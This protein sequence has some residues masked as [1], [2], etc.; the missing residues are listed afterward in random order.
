[1]ST[2]FAWN[3]RGLN[4][5]RR[6]RMTREWINIHRPLLGAFLETHVQENNHSRILNAIPVGWR[7]FGNFAEHPGG[8]IVVVWDPSVSVF[9]YSASAQAVT[10]GIFVM[11]ENINFTVTFVYGSNDVE[12]R[13]SLWNELS[14]MNRTTPVAYSPWS[15]VGDFNQIIRVSNHSDYPSSVIDISGMEDMNMALQDA[16]LFE[17]QA[18]GSPFTWWNNQVDN[19]ISKKIDHALIN[20]DWA[21]NFP[22]SYAE[23]LEPDQSDHAPCA[24]KIPCLNRQ[25]RKPF[26][27]FHHVLDHP[28]YAATISEAWQPDQFSGSNQYK[29]VRSLKCLKGDLR[30]LNKTH[31]SDISKRVKEQSRVVEGLQRTLLSTPDSTTAEEEHRE[32]A[33]LNVLLTAEQKFFRQRSRVRWADVGDRNTPFFHKTVAQRVTRNHIHFLK[34][35]NDQ[36]IGTATGIKAHSAAYFERIL[37]HTDMPTSPVTVDELQGLLDF[38]CSELQQRYLSREVSAAEIRATV[39]SMPLNKSSGPDGYCVEFLRASWDTVGQDVINAVSEFF[40]N[41]RLLKDLNTTAITLIPKN[42]EACRL[43]DFRPI[44]CCNIV[45]KV[46]SKIITNRLKPL[47][48]TCV[49]P[50]QSAF[51]KGRSLGDNV[52]LAT[53]LIQSYNSANCQHSCTI[54]VDIRKAFDTVCWDFV[55][56]L[57]QAQSFPPIFITWIRECMTS[58]RFSVSINGELAGFFAGKKG[59]RQGDSISPYLFIMIME[60]LSKLFEKLADEEGMRLHPLCANPRVTHLLF[61]DDLLVFSDGSCHSIFGIKGVMRIFKS[62]TGLDINPTKSE[63]FLGGYAD[64]EASVLSDLSGFKRGSFP[65]RYLGLPL[66]PSR[67]NFESLQ[68]FLERVTNKLHSWT[69]KCLSFAGKIRMVTSVIYGMVNF[70]SSVFTLSK[71]FYAKVDSLCSAFLW[72]NKTT[73]AVGARVSWESICKPKQEGGL[74]IRKLEDYQS[75]FQL[76]RVWNYFSSGE[77]LWSRWLSNNVFNRHSYWTMESTARLSATVQNMISM[78]LT[79]EYFLRC[80]IGDGRSASFWFD[81]WTDMGPLMSAI[82]P[83]GPRDLRLPISSRV[84]E[85]TND[86][87]NWQLPPA[88]SYAVETLQIV[89]S[90]MPPPSPS[91]GK[92]YYLWRSGYSS[93]DKKFSTK[94]TWEQIRVAAE[95][96][97]WVNLVWFKEEIPRCSFITWLS[98]L[99]RLPTRDRLSSWGMNIPTQCMLCT[100]EE[101]THDHLFFRCSYASSVWSHFC[102]GRLLSSPPGSIL[103]CAA[104]LRDHQF[105]SSPR[106]GPVLKLILQVAIY[107]LWRERNARIFTHVSSP[108]SVLFSKIDRMVRDRLLSIPSPSPSQ[109]SLLQLYLSFL[110]DV[111]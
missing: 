56:K 68:P 12:A 20:Q 106:A 109:A 7:Y 76:K 1:M 82:G 15:V 27:F 104:V 19:P 62:W 6:H 37:G 110:Y 87:G 81:W 36:F 48:Q 99:Q 73:S 71:Q 33:K 93:Y 90:T 91:R 42:P 103:E 23:F 77:S 9:V 97:P 69:V 17:A 95:P 84:S 60:V 74:G 72:N 52:L 2:F 67:L 8:R 61:A 30:L 32:R 80:A 4:H 24:F 89:L 63:I 88:R 28:D 47:L 100:L 94:K 18:K 57:L 83:T 107:C 5:E 101:E 92:D 25:S 58:P 98:V 26:K 105:R 29:L 38:R 11:A 22:D 59:L 39:F 111:P 53:E 96:V 79:V 64:I 45:Y 85:A 16:E 40:R 65:T 35:D 102:V 49:S 34:D 41:G 10:C 54:K 78:K 31:Y 21:S 108:A 3:V 44:S 66:N 50:N 43:G 13:K 55:I 86:D 51:L 14:L 70:W 46:I 75:V